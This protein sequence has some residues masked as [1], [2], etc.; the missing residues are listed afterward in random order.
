MSGWNA[1]SNHGHQGFTWSAVKF[2]EACRAN[3]P[4]TI[5]SADSIEYKISIKPITGFGA[6]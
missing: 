3:Q 6:L 2:K 4:F 1:I 5:L